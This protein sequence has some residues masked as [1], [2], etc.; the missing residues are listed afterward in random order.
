MDA[1]RFRNADHLPKRRSGVPVPHRELPRQRVGI[2]PQM[3]GR[4]P[5]YDVL[6]ESDHW[7]EVT[8]SVV[9]ARL[10]PPPPLR[11]FTAAE[12]RTLTAFCD[13]VLAQ[14]AE[15]RIPVVPGIDQKLFEGRTD[16]FRYVDMPEQGQ[17]WRLAAQGLDE[18]ARA[19]GAAAYAD[20]PP[21]V[22]HDTCAA[23]ASGEIAGEAW[24]R[25]PARRAWK[26]LMHDVLGVFYAHPWAWNEIG[27]GGPAY[28]RGFMRLGIDL[29]EPYEGHDRVNVDPVRDARER[30]LS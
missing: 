16:G 5:L 30:G 18:A 15:P 20:A 17:A 22:R 3:H 7:D 27:F 26:A 6:A 24:E 10:A 1:G 14:D 4:Y 19:R 8:R 25:L 11:F 28:P 12:A 21:D 9:L 2:T 29:D 13:D 23:F